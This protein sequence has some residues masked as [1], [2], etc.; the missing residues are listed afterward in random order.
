MP[1]ERGF[2]I[3]IVADLQ[4]PKLSTNRE[5]FHSRIQ[6]FVATNPEPVTAL[7]PTG[8]EAVPTSR[9]AG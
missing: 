6:A 8:C 4:L 3:K 5:L 2:V 1:N 9:R 7:V